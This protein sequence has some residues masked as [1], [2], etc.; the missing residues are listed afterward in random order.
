MSQP[1][2][3]RRIT[4]AGPARLGRGQGYDGPAHCPAPREGL[5]PTGGGCS[6][7]GLAGTGAQRQRRASE[8]KPRERQVPRRPQPLAPAACFQIASFSRGR[9]SFRCP[10]IRAPPPRPRAH[11]TRARSRAQPGRRGSG[12]RRPR[13]WEEGALAGN[14]CHLGTRGRTAHDSRTSR[15]IKL[16]PRSSL[17]FSDLCGRVVLVTAG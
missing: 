9:V 4:P 7:E 15:R 5:A 6:P 10:E 14:P 17:K 11:V 13:P 2:G 16:G 1:P 3:G 12:G 8:Q